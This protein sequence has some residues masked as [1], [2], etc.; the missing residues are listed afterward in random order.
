[1]DEPMT[2]DPR[3]IAALRTSV[4]R[5]LTRECGKLPGPPFQRG[6]DIPAYW[7]A[8][9][10]V[11]GRG[12]LAL[13]VSRELPIGTFGATSYAFASAASIGEALDVFRHDSQ[14]AV[15]GLTTRVETVGTTASLTIDG[16]EVLGPMLD[17]LI[18][19]VALRC[20][21]LA[22]PAVE[23]VNVELRSPEPSDLAP[24]REHFTVRPRFGSAR[25][26]L[27]IPAAQL[28]QPLRTSYNT[29]RDVVGGRTGGSAADQ[30]RAHVRAW[31]REPSE[32]ADVARALGMSARTLQRRLDEDGVTFRGLVL[33]IKI[34]VAKE[35]LADEHLTIADVSTAVGFARLSAFSRAFTQR[36]G[37]SPSKFR[38]AR[39]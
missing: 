11:Y 25:N 8:A 14:R 39:R 33:D 26:V 13:S 1:M 4:E 34:E 23:I 38:E 5:V 21:Q 37:T 6:E 16:P 9:E 20:Q 31:I 19:L 24:W 35:M 28:R 30:V 36:T 32:L 15:V 29:V 27:A 10:A 12:D 18:A 3:A 2:I 17:V 7:R 22:E